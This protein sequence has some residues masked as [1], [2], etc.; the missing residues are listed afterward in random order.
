MTDTNEMRK[1]LEAAEARSA[2]LARALE[3]ARPFVSQFEREVGWAELT[4]Q[5]ED[6]HALLEKIDRLIPPVAKD[7]HNG[8]EIKF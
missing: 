1:A 5:E 2:A 6:A 3:E 8:E 4:E 7:N